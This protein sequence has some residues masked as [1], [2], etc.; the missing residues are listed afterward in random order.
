MK[1]KMTIDEALVFATE[2]SVGQTFHEDSQ[3]WR[4]V[5]MLLAQE[6]RRLRAE[7]EWHA[8]LAD[9]Q[10]FANPNISGGDAIRKETP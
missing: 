4:V 2:W 7:R 5:C 3:G 10:L 9:D 1:L 6:V 8:K